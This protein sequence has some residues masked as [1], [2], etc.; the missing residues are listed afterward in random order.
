MQL[1]HVRK[2]DIDFVRLEITVLDR[3]KNRLIVLMLNVNLMV[4]GVIGDLGLIVRQINRAHRV[5]KPDRDNVTT[6]PPGRVVS[7]ALVLAPLIQQHVPQI[8]Q[9]IVLLTRI[10]VAIFGMVYGRKDMVVQD[11]V[12][13]D[14][15]LM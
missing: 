11:Q 4:T 13:L 15:M 10:R 1:Q 7:T 5:P 3:K 9:G 12:E 14:P 2:R 6:H 8:A